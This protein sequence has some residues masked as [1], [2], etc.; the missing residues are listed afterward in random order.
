[1]HA[2]KIFAEQLL[3]RPLCTH[4]YRQQTEAEA[5]LSVAAEGRL[6]FI[7]EP[8]QIYDE[9]LAVLRRHPDMQVVESFGEK[10]G[11]AVKAPYGVSPPFTSWTRK[12]KVQLQEF[13]PE[14]EARE[15]K[16]ATVQKRTQL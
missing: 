7:F 3:I 5:A 6:R 9:A 12:D 14:Q 11:F 13:E 1:M 8:E 15:A 4:N 2:N 10:I 16:S